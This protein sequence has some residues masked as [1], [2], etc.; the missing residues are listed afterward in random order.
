MAAG[1]GRT[2][3]DPGLGANIELSGGDAGGLFD[4]V[5]I[6]KTLAGQ[7]IATEEPPPAL[8]EIEPAGPC[9]NED[10]MEPRML[11][12]PGAG[13]STV[14][15]AEIISDNEDVARRIV[16]FDILKESDVVCRVA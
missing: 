12:Q 8:L 13:L 10:L 5:R 2:T 15:A 9:W 16:S 11:C 3:P 14:M 7:G 6:G 4:L 1:L